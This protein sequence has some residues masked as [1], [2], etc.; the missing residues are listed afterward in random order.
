MQDGIYIY[1]P[2]IPRLKAE[3]FKAVAHPGRI[4]ILEILAAGE[5]PVSELA[6]ELDAEQPYVSQQLAVL[7]RAG[8]VVTRREGARIVYGLADERVADLLEVSREILVDLYTATG[9]ELRA[10]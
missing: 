6:E 10:S 1:M 9:E 3:F 7:R 8:F 5:R 4:R 2:D